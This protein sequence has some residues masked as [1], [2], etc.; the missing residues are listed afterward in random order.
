V[1]DEATNR[2]AIRSMT[3]AEVIAELVRDDEVAFYDAVSQS[4]SAVNELSDDTLKA[5]A[6]ELVNAVRESATTDW[7]PKDGVRGAMRS[8]VRRLLAKCDYPSDEE[9]KVVEL[10]LEQAQL[11]PNDAASE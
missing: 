3:P 2:Y 1:L 10:V 4:E 7:N 5:I 9:G 8:R 11:F 6:R